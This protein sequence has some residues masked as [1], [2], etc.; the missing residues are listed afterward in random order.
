[1]RIFF[2]AR[3][4]NVAAA[5]LTERLKHV[6]G[7]RVHVGI[8]VPHGCT[9]ATGLPEVELDAGANPF[10]GLL[11]RLIGKLGLGKEASALE[12]AE[13]G[14]RLV[15]D[16]RQGAIHLDRFELT[17]IPEQSRPFK[18]LLELALANGESVSHERLAEVLGGKGA[19]PDV[20]KDTKRRTLEA[21]KLSFSK[22][23]L[24]LPSLEEIIVTRAGGYA[25]GVPA[26]VS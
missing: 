2:F 17:S 6:A 20:A 1:V 9:P 14:H 5:D 18:F 8:V 25:L 26:F 21:M 3:K 12:Q 22:K 10:D 23:G 19:G 16:R 4:P 15:I 24:A 13:P 11:R 7:G